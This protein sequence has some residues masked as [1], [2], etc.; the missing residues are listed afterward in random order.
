MLIDEIKVILNSCL[1]EN[2]LP[3]STITYDNNKDGSV[4]VNF[5][6][7]LMMKIIDNNN[8]CVQVPVA[9]LQTVELDEEIEVK[10]IKSLVGYS[11]VI[12]NTL[13][14]S[15]KESH[16]LKLLFLWLIDNFT[17][18]PFACCSSYVECSDK[19]QCVHNDLLYAKGCN[20]RRNLENGKVFYGINKNI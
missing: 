12:I 13:S 5:S 10:N 17:A 7:K 6:K 15:S 20:Y 4:S 18:E 9:F 14:L 8:R 16:L 1:E 2:R 11:R 19:L 3:L